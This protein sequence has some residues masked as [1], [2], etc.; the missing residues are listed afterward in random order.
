MMS[1]FDVWQAMGPTTLTAADV[2]TVLDAVARVARA[3]DSAPAAPWTSG[4]LG[5][6]CPTCGI[7]LTADHDCT[8]E[9]VDGVKP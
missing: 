1:G 9:T 2:A 6:P 5:Y 4:L 7:T 8:A 3:T